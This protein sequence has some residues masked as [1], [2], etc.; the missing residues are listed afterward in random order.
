MTY[1]LDVYPEELLLKIA[2]DDKIVSVMLWRTCRAFSQLKRSLPKKGDV[3]IMAAS[4]YEYPYC[5]FYTSI[6][7]ITRWLVDDGCKWDESVTYNAAKDGD[8][9]LL[10][11]LIVLRCPYDESV[12]RVVVEEGHIDILERLRNDGCFVNIGYS[13]YK[14]RFY[15]KY[16]NQLLTAVRYGRID[17][18]K[19]L[20]HLGGSVKSEEAC[21]TAAK[22][23]KLHTLI[24]LRRQKYPWNVIECLRVAKCDE[25]YKW[26]KVRENW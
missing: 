1:L 2:G 7:R 19:W 5:Y 4:R 9:G 25:T 10:T 23:G 18:L 21:Y 11:R 8:L 20:T 15:E 26:I 12:L 13:W 6:P 16:H 22:Y 17:I 14:G 3:C 24:Y